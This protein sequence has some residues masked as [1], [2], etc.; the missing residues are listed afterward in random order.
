MGVYMPHHTDARDLLRDQIRAFEKRST[1]A[2]I[3]MTDI[4]SLLSPEDS[5]TVVQP[6]GIKPGGEFAKVELITPEYFT[7]EY[8]GQHVMLT[9]Q[10]TQE[11]HEWL[12]ECGIEIINSS[13]EH[14]THFAPGF[15]YR[16]GDKARLDSLVARSRKRKE[17]PNGNFLGASDF[18]RARYLQQVRVKATIDAIG[19][20]RV[21]RSKLDVLQMSNSM[22][23]TDLT[24]SIHC[25]D[26][27]NKKELP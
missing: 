12:E 4:N 22:K 24:K 2:I 17:E 1:H 19:L 27:I 16:A 14:T 15:A 6:V 10:R 5:L 8:E 25:H 23:N 26:Y 13:A 3:L 7:S 18:V 21:A 20:N 9:P 11:T